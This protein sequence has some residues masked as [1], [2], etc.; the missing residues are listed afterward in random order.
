MMQAFSLRG[1]FQHRT[2][3]G[4]RWAVLPRASM[5]EPL[6]LR[7][8]AD[9]CQLIREKRAPGRDLLHRREKADEIRQRND[10]FHEPSPYNSV[11]PIPRAIT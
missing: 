1:D 3:G 2:Q 4:D 8:A 10:I 5:S 7:S 9:S 6:G 11:H